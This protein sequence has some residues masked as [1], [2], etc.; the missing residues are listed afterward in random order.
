MVERVTI[1]Q[2]PFIDG[3]PAAEL[4]MLVGVTVPLAPRDMSYSFYVGGETPSSR[5]WN[6]FLT[7]DADVSVHICYTIN[8]SDMFGRVHLISCSAL[9][10]LCPSF[11]PTLRAWF[12]TR[13]RGQLFAISR[14]K[15]QLV[16]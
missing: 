2:S 4:A 12:S 3:I 5:M 11:A 13:S 6:G 8:D 10:H 7:V 1:I 15:C 9:Y 14:D 16:S